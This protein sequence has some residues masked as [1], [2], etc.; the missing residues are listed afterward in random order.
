MGD[1]V[2]VP[3]IASGGVGTLEHLYEGVGGGRGERG[4][5][6]VDLPLRPAH[7]PR[8][9]G[10]PERPRPADQALNRIVSAR[11]AA[12]GYRHHTK[13]RARARHV[14]RRC[15]GRTY[16]LA[17]GGSA[18]D[19][20]AV[21][22]HFF[23]RYRSSSTPRTTRSTSSSTRT[24]T[25]TAPPSSPISRRG[26][27]HSCAGRPSSRRTA[28]KPSPYRSNSP[29][30]PASSR[31]VCEPSARRPG[32]CG[33]RRSGSRPERPRRACAT[34]PRRSA[35][36]SRGAELVVRGEHQQLRTRVGSDLRVVGRGT[37]PQRRRDR[38]PSPRSVGRRR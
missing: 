33:R 1:A 18:P 19:V 8:G 5:R 22:D 13:C 16:H 29:V 6:G 27:R 9:Q 4:A 2:D 15:H 24:R 34:S 25:A 28:S 12:G 14:C 3:V 23:R 32:R 21:D 11:S 31:H 30:S 35:S 37:E 38:R 26:A 10:L 36:I 17:G 7:G 20:G